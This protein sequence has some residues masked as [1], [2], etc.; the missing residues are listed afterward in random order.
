MG[1]DVGDGPRSLPTKS[2]GCP[3]GSMLGSFTD[4]NGGKASDGQTGQLL[5]DACDPTFAGGRVSAAEF[6]LKTDCAEA[7]DF[8]VWID[9]QLYCWSGRV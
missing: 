2:D 5:G 9:K 1:G 6:A 8:R 3:Q 4:L 7:I